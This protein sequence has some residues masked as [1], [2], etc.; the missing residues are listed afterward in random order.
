L[1]VGSREALLA[2]ARTMSADMCACAP[3][4]KSDSSR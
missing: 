1:G 4:S 2:L 3:E